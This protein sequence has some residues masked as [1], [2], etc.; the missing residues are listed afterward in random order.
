MNV[1]M[2]ITDQ[3][4]A[5]Q[6]FPRGWAE[7]NL[8][9]ATRLARHGLTFTRAF[10]NAC[11]CSPSRASLLT[12]YFPAQ[13]G[14]KWTLEEGMSPP[15]NPQQVLPTTLPNLATVMASI[16]YS[17]V[18]KGKF[19]LTK[20][21]NTRTNQFVPSD[22][23]PYGWD[24]WDPPDAGANQDYDQFGGGFIDND[25]RFLND[26]GPTMY[27]QQ[28][29]LAW[30]KAKPAA[31]KPFFAV[32]SL[33]NP[34]DVLAYPLTAFGYG[35]TP[36]DVEGDIGLPETVGEDLSTK[37]DVQQQFVKLTN[38]G[39]GKMD[40]EQQTAYIN[41][42]GNL[43]KESDAH[44]VQIL[45]T[46]EQEGLLDNTLIIRTS[47]HG[48]MGMAH[49]GMRQKNF[50]FYEEALRV[51]LTY[52]NPKLFPEPRVSE[53]M[54]SHVDFLPTLAALFGAPSSACAAWEGKDYSPIVLN[55][56]DKPVQDYI[57]FTYDDYQ[58]G[59][60]GGPYPGPFNHIVSIREERYKL[61]KYYDEKHPHLPPQWEMYDLLDDPNES[62]NLAYKD[63]QRNEDQEAAY[64]RLQ[65]RLAEV[66]QTRLQPLPSSTSGASDAATA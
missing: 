65:A 2:F 36:K 56:D 38:L 55:A 58:S 8:P 52:S 50:N 32:A 63:Y 51:P 24:G 31:D 60:A 30:L 17:T 10:C 62:T 23:T 28:G 15:D 13:H 26:D 43:M 4:R 11:M 22:I 66:E 7:E 9:G 21:A 54:V 19:H 35:Y 18:Y 61:A 37:P 12:G 1:L 27:G 16:G 42:Y 6:H 40:T 3:E 49:G 59:Q 14:V 34:H 57:V 33:V 47:D 5:I 39:M 45:D 25:G 20:P 41:F 44:L 29:I 53:A 48:E 64:I 46:L